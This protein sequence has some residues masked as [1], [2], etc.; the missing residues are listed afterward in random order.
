MVTA[1]IVAAGLSV[2]TPSPGNAADLRGFDPGNIMSDEVFFDK[3]TMTEAEIQQ[4]FAARI[5]AC[6]PGATCL[7]NWRGDTWS[8]A[9][10]AQ[11]GSYQGAASESAARIV[12]KVAQA[13]GINPRVLI[14]TLQKEQGLVTSKNP[15]ASAWRAAM[16]YGCPDTAP[17]DAQYYGFYNQ[18]YK[19]AWQFKRYAVNPGGFRYRAG[20]WNT[21]QWHPSASCG[22]SSVYISNQATAGLYNYTPYRPNAAALAAGYGTGDSCSTYGNRNF[23]SYFT[24]WFGPTTYNVPG[25]IG[26]FWYSIG[27]AAS[28]VGSPLS[29]AAEETANGGGW[30]Q[31]FTKGYIYVSRAGYSAALRKDS[32]IF[33]RYAAANSQYGAYGWPRFSERCGTTTCLAAFDRASIGWTSANGVQVVEE[34]VNSL[35]AS[36]GYERGPLGVPVSARIT[37]TS[38]VDRQNFTNGVAYVVGDKAFGLYGGILDAYVARGG[39]AGSLGA[40]TTSMTCGTQGCAAE[41][42]HGVLASSGAASVAW[43]VTDDVLS[44]Y[45]QEG[46]VAGALGAPTGQETTLS[47]GRSQAFA[48]GTIYV[49]ASADV[50]LFARSGLSQRYA[51]LGGPTGSLGWPTGA[52]QCDVSSCMLPLQ[53]G[54]LAW[55]LATDVQLIPQSV[56]GAYITAGA[57]AG[58]GVPST[59]LISYGA[60]SAQDFTRGYIYTSAAGSHYL[61]KDSGIMARYAQLGSQYSALGWPASSEECGTGCWVRFQAGRIGW[62]ATTGV[63]VVPKEIA[64]GYDA[65]GGPVGALGMPVSEAY[66]YAVNGGGIAQDYQGGYVYM[67]SSGS[68]GLRK[69]SAIFQRYGALGSQYSALGWPVTAEACVGTTSCSVD[70]QHGRISWLGSTGA[71]TVTY[72]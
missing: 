26:T 30:T 27:A 13:C 7:I 4:F 37:D 12:Y 46:G 69:N 70:F 63:R 40:P 72:H 47:G 14:V 1:V 23:F 62:S 17:C 35:Y 9:A 51:Q 64:T 43:L 44:V 18:V 22:S 5:G 42:E 21:I 54:V 28:E 58:P 39:A 55:S 19:A 16:G 24:D 33:Q 60:G 53:R 48:G 36:Q 10:D 11:C 67:T 32:G 38:G 6:S 45:R 50:A 8:R 49:S 56:M 61:R 52:E 29:G 71:I 66:S 2:A 41:F 31:E 57:L 25:A 68:V 20:Q 65:L 3:S 34:P 15:S 59:P